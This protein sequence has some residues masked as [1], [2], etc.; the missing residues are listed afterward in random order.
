MSWVRPGKATYGHS[1]GIIMQH[2]GLIRAPGDVGNLT[3][4]SFPVTYEIVDPIPDSVMKSPELIDHCEAYITAARRLEDL[5][6]KAIAAGCGFLALLQPVIAEAV[7]IP[8]FSSALIQVPLISIA[9]GKRPIGI[10]TASSAS[11]TESHFSAVGWSS[12]DYP[13]TVVGL[14]DD[15]PNFGFSRDNLMKLGEHPELKSELESGM[16]RLASLLLEKDP[17][18]GAI[19]L[20][21]TNMP[22]FARSIQ[23]HVGLPVFDVVTMIN[24][25]HE[26]IAR[27]PYMGHY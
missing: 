19:L 1:V 8:V 14:E 2:D 10:I 27:R 25:V 21:C 6:C 11:L 4:F 3:T 12:A 20:E 15:Y 23:D 18:V 17:K 13:V 16:I 26:S 24:M 9:L 22:P 5:G 7:S